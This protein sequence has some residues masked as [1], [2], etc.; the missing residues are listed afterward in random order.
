MQETPV[1]LDISE[2]FNGAWSPDFD[3]FADRAKQ[4]GHAADNRQ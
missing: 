1:F 4:S 2:D 3:S